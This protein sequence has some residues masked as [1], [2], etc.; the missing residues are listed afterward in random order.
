MGLC[1]ALLSVARQLTV[2]VL[3]LQTKR[4]GLVLGTWETHRTLA[5]HEIKTV[6]RGGGV[7]WRGPRRGFTQRVVSHCLLWVQERSADGKQRGCMVKLS[8][9]P[10]TPNLW[11]PH[12]EHTER[13]ATTLVREDLVTRREGLE[14]KQGL[15]LIVQKTITAWASLGGPSNAASSIAQLCLGLLNASTSTRERGCSSFAI[16]VCGALWC[17]F[18]AC[19]QANLARRRREDWGIDL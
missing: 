17:V 7:G 10:T 14:P 5:E 16:G 8:R 6:E 11:Q 2:L 1:S 15:C 3:G 18:P 12:C 13:C 4:C 9:T 19:P